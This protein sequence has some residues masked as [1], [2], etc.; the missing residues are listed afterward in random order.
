MTEHPMLD[1]VPLAGARREMTHMNGEAQVR[2]QLLQ[3]HL[4]Q[5]TA[6]AVTAAPISGD[7]KFAGPRI[8]LGP[9]VLPPLA[10]GADRE[11]RR[12]E[13]DAHAHPALIQAQVEHPV[14]NDLAELLINEVVDLDLFG[15]ALGLPLPPAILERGDELLLL[16][17]HGDHRLA[18]LV[19]AIERTVDILE[20]RIAIRMRT[21][22]LGLT[23]ALQAIPAMLERRPDRPGAVRMPIARQRLH[24]IH[25]ALAGPAQRRHWIASRAR[26]NQSRLHQPG[27][28]FGQPLAPAC[29]ASPAS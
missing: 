1:L 25:R 19:K 21:P 14:R 6:A 7:Q 24:R 26:F 16:G 15:L 10:D 4:P 8:A 3:R 9:H 12:V 17:I 5:A 27:I 29:T 18:A 11:L 28:R 22:F 13:I 20:Q 2:R 23:V